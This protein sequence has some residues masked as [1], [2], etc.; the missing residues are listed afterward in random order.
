MRILVVEDN[1]IL[2]KILSDHL[3]EG[4]HRVVPAYE[5]GLASIFCE[6]KDFDVIVIDL[7]LPDLN[8]IDVLERLKRGN[9][10][11]RVIVITG[12]PEL[13]EEL[14]GRLAAVG[15]EAVIEK[16]FAFSEVDEA[17][18]RLH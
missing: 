17:L 7:V 12:F 4:G 1:H 2:A 8:G 16:P 14:S 6:H 11:P 5:G 13:L 18:S 10:M 3:A 9:R 15:V